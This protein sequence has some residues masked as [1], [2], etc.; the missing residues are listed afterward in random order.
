MQTFDKELGTR[1]MK[2]VYKESLVDLVNHN[3]KMDLIVLRIGLGEI[4]DSAGGGDFVRFVS[5]AK[6]IE[7]HL[8]TTAKGSFIKARHLILKNKWDVHISH[9]DRE[10]LPY[11]DGEFNL[12]AD[13][14]SLDKVSPVKIEKVL[15][16]Y[17]RVL[18]NDGKLLLFSWVT[19][20]L[21]KQ[22]GDFFYHVDKFKACLKQYFIVEEIHR[23]YIGGL[24]KRDDVSM[25]R[26]ICRKKK[27]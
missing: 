15:S 18:K 6:K 25:M 5:P 9:S 27:V 2:G 23:Y 16:E 7:K 8:V 24:V 22:S 19:Y 1:G 4:L 17:N 11:N 21:C 20:Y 10:I 26:F 3:P 14:S 13:F 12:L